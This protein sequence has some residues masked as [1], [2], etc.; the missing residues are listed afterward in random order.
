VTCEAACILDRKVTAAV[1]V[2][3][4]RLSPTRSVRSR[5][6]LLMTL[7]T[8]IFSVAGTAGF[9]VPSSFKSMSLFNPSVSV[10]TGRSVLMTFDAGYFLYV[11]LKTFLLIDLAGVAVPI[12]PGG[13][14]RG[15]LVRTDSIGHQRRCQCYY[16]Y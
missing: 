6:S 13:I 3:V 5:R 11:T 16:N 10:A 8:C 2:T 12:D 4:K 1:T 9:A 15:W 7:D 14:V